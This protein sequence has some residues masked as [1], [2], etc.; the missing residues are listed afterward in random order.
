M[1]GPTAR[2]DPA[3]SITG[4]L[5]VIAGLTISDSGKFLFYDGNQHAW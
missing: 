1:G 3:E 2:L 5:N 4:V